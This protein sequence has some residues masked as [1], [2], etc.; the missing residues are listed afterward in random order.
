[1]IIITTIK[2]KKRQANVAT[3]HGQVIT[4]KNNIITLVGY[5]TIKFKNIRIYKISTQQ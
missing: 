4:L 5:D 2:S 1:M 3:R